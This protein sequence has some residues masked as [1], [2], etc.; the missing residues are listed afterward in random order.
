M[1]VVKGKP[2]DEI[3]SFLLPYKNVLIVG[4]DG[5]TQ[6]PRGLREA[7]TYA[8]LV[9]MG[10]KLRGKT[11]LKCRATTVAKQCDNHICSTTLTPQLEGV[12]AIL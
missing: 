7:M 3:L 1:I 6:P 8:M 4:C 2:L 5:C 9:E 10:A 12:D 11:D